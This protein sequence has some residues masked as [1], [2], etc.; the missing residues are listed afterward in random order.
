MALGIGVSLAIQAPINSALARSVF[1]THLVSA[2]VNFFI[3]TVCLF[4]LLYFNGLLSSNTIKTT[5]SQEY[6]KYLGGVLGAFIVFAA[7][8]LSPKI[9]LTNMF[10][11]LVVGQITT[12]L[13]LD[14]FGVFGLMVKEVS[15]FKILGLAIIFFGLFIFFYKE[16]NIK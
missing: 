3:G 10:L 8:F 6:W 5:I 9:G 1:N 13:I 15:I 2:F 7:S 11:M 4:L 16:L 12:S 14:R